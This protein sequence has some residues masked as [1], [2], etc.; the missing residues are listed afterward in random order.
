MEK[1]RAVWAPSEAGRVGVN[2]LPG[3]GL[4]PSSLRRSLHRR[5]APLG[6]GQ[7]IHATPS[8]TA[9]GPGE[10]DKPSTLTSP[11]KGLSLACSGHVLSPGP[12]PG[13]WN[14]GTLIGQA[15]A[16]SLTVPPETWGEEEGGSPNEQ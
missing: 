5:P 13:P 8:P 7:A 2:G 15:G 11:R 9:Q 14:N 4:P 6:P 16:T 12:I 3:P 10:G 1:A